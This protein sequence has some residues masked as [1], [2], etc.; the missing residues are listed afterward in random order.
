MNVQESDRS[1][2]RKAFV[3]AIATI[4][5]EKAIILFFFFSSSELGGQT[6]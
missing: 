2:I 3:K 5:K 4:A 1:I 6:E